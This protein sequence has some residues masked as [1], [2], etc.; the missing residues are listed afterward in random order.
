L[1]KFQYH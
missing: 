1:K